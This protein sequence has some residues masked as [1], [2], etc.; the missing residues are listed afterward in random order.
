MASFNIHKT[1]SLALTPEELQAL[2]TKAKEL[3]DTNTQQHPDY[4]CLAL[5]GDTEHDL[6]LCVDSARYT[7]SAVKAKVAYVENFQE[8]RS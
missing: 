8:Q 6:R 7:D 4:L 5:Y 1:I 3:R 2:A